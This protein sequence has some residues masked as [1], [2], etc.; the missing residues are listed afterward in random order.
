MSVYAD[1]RDLPEATAG[2]AVALGNFDGI[3]AGHR[4]VIAAARASG[5]RLAVATFEPP[6]RALFR[7]D[8]PPFRIFSPER[9][10]AALLGLGAEAVFELPFNKDMASM[11]DEAFARNV[12]H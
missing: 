8:D 6:P 7:P 2:M 3:H 10:N 5:H 1:Y 4:A 12:L 9:R 11:T